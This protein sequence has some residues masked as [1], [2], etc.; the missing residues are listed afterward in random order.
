MQLTPPRSDVATDFN[1]TYDL[2]A[3][4]S[5]SPIQLSYP[6]YQYPGTST[7]ST[8]TPCNLV[9]L[10]RST[11][12]QYQGMVQ[13]GVTPQKEG[14][15]NGYGLFWF[16][17]ALDPV[18]V[19]RSY[20]VNGYYTPVASRT[21]LEVLTGYRVNQVQ[22]DTSKRATGV[23]VQQRGTPDGQNVKVLKANAEIVLT[24]GWLHT[25]QIL[26]RSG[27]GPTSVLSRANIPVVVD[28][29]GVG[30]N[31]QDHPSAS[32]SFRCKSSV[33]LLWLL[34]ADDI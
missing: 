12:I 6:T 5:N 34:E 18:N 25:P 1:I 7:S 23:T 22:F 4:G 24:A 8:G 13:A 14:G 3:Y 30:S 15:L 21:N 27:V 10:T 29:P 19:R 33:Y 17:G 26:Q 16:P 20:A 11:E 32:S 2:A 28:L 9:E 31:L